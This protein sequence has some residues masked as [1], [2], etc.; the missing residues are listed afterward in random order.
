ML[1]RGNYLV[2]DLAIS[3]GRPDRESWVVTRE[4]MDAIENRLKQ[5]LAARL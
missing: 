5:T 2:Q 3:C 4:F 1:T